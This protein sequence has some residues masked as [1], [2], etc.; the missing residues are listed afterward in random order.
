MLNFK[1]VFVLMMVGL[2]ALGWAK[3]AFS[4]DVSEDMVYVAANDDAE[5]YDDSSDSSEEDVYIPEPD[6]GEGDEDSYED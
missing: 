1:K 6:S 3:S 2:M 4:E 5:P